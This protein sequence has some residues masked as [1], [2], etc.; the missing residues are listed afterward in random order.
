MNTDGKQEASKEHKKGQVH[1]RTRRNERTRE[2]LRREK[3][4]TPLPPHTSW[5]KELL[6]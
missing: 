6:S 4:L 5:V 3:G 2:I 1:E